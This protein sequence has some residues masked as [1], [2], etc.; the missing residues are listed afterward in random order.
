MAAFFAEPISGVDGIIVSPNDY[1]KEVKKVL[2]RYGVCLAL[3][4]VQTGLGRAGRLWGSEVYGVVLEVVT[5][6]KALG[7]GYP[8]AAVLTQ[9]RLA[10]SLEADD[11]F[12]TWGANLVMCA[13]ALVI[14][15]YV[16]ENRLWE[17]AERMGQQLLRRLKELESRFELIGEARGKGLMV[18]VEIVKSKE[19]RE[20]VPSECAAIRRQCAERGLIVGAGGWYRN[21]IR[22]QPPFVITEE[23]VEGAL[24]VFKDAV[25]A[26][27][28]AA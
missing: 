27:N 9:S 4:E 7:N 18:G 21:V 6:A 17:N 3:D 20:P 24:E 19:T 16:V 25:R 10:D 11:H 14:V 12:S 8:I 26:V 15:N 13:A 28:L 5:L 22:I 1:F 23:N 2:D